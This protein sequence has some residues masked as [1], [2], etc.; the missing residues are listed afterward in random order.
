M[1]INSMNKN[2]NEQLPH[3]LITLLYKDVLIDDNTHLDKIVFEDLTVPKDVLIIAKSASINLNEKQI[4][5]LTSILKALK[6][7]LNDVHLITN[8]DEHFG[9]YKTMVSKYSPNKI[10][11]FGLGP[12]DIELPMNFPPFQIQA[13]EN[14]K[15]LCAPTLED[16]E[17]NKS[18]KLTLWQGLQ[19]LFL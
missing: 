15:Y 9:T 4:L 13:F 2:N 18:T 10:I 11:L 6:L 7:G 3:S 19:K 12:S 17:E 5:F 14:K 16:I 8:S 1:T